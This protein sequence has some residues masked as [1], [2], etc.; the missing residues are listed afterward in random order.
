MKSA[1]LAIGIMVGLIIVVFVMKYINRDKKVK[2]EYDE[3]QQLVRGRSYMYGFWGMAI[4]NVI[5]LLV[6]VENMDIIKMLGMNAFFLPL[7]VGIIVQISHAIFND[8]YMAMNNNFAR[9]M[10][11]MGIV[12]VINLVCGIM[13]IVRNGFI[14]NGE[15]Y[16]TFINLEVGVMFIILCIEMAIKKCID[17]K[18]DAE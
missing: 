2:S 15:V 8:G 16:P 3:R 14:Q 18:E 4:A 9:F 13:P 10:V 7:F 1:G 12:S 5:M 17:K 6:G 11:V